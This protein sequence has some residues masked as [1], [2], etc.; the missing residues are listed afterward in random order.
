MCVKRISVCL[1]LALSL[2]ACGGGK[3]TNFI[4]KSK[5]LLDTRKAFLD[6]VAA[7]ETAH[8]I[9]KLCP[10]YA[11]NDK[12]EE[13]ILE[14]FAKAVENLP[15]RGRAPIEEVIAFQQNAADLMQTKQAKTY[16]VAR[17]KQN[18]IDR[19]VGPEAPDLICRV[20][21]EEY[22]KQSQIGRFLLRG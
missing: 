9:N 21:E 3:N 10:G 11:F 16:I 14:K 6:D 13:A 1:I 18:L 19:G 8:R 15:A 5:I 12:E 7:A 17:V 20:G 22:Q 4:P 2:S